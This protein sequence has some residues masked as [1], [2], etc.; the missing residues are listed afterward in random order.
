MWK[1]ITCLIATR[2]EA[3]LNVQTFLLESICSLL[4]GL[5]FNLLHLMLCFSAKHD[6][7]IQVFGCLLLNFGTVY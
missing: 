1:C 5:I 7:V 4:L 6:V 2:E 3:Q